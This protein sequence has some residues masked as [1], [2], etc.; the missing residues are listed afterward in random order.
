VL[1]RGLLASLHRHAAILP[2][3][4]T[5]VWPSMATSRLTLASAAITSGKTYPTPI[6]IA[7]LQ[8]FRLSAW[9]S[10]RRV[11]FS[12]PRQPSIGGWRKFPA[13][14]QSPCLCGVAGQ[15]DEDCGP[16][17]ICGNPPPPPG[18]WVWKLVLQETAIRDLDVGLG[19]V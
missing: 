13:Q 9:P 6:P 11:V 3:K 8:E 16:G 1:S 10:R 7:L 2:A 4:P 18:E 12:W 19:F 14:I 15:L 17:N 5:Q